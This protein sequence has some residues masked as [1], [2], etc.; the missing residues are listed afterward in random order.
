MGVFKFHT[1]ISFRTSL[2][3]QKHLFDQNHVWHVLPQLWW[4]LPNMNDI[5]Q[6]ITVFCNSEKWKNEWWIL[7][8]DL[9]YQVRSMFLSTIMRPALSSSNMPGPVSHLLFPRI[10]VW[11][12]ASVIVLTGN[13]LSLAI[14][15]MVNC[16]RLLPAVFLGHWFCVYYCG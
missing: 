16:N 2:F 13:L 6:I 15:I 1:M 8:Q 11:E 9:L 7:P 10:A 12:V 3:L 4:H 14:S 5:Q